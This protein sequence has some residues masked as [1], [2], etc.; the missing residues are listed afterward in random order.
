MS[1]SCKALHF[2]ISHTFS[3]PVLNFYSGLRMLSLSNVKDRIKEN[4]N[5]HSLN[6]S[7]IPSPFIVI[8][9]ENMHCAEDC[10][11]DD[12]SLKCALVMF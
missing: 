3:M 12:Y 9:K 4:R 1:W 5:V 7:A 10:V 11:E 2:F 8:E 6:Q